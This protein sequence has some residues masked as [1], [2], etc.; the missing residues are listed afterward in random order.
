LVTGKY[1]NYNLT[2]KP[3]DVFCMRITNSSTEWI[4]VYDNGSGDF[5]ALCTPTSSLVRGS[6]IYITGYTNQG[7]AIDIDAFLL[8]VNASTGAYSGFGTYGSDGN[9]YGYQIL[10]DSEENILIRGKKNSNCWL[11]KPN[12][13]WEKE[14]ECLTTNGE[15]ISLTNDNNYILTGYDNDNFVLVKLD[16]EG[17]QLWKKYY[18]YKT[19]ERPFSV[20]QTSD[21]GFLIAGTFQKSFRN[22]DICLIKTDIN[23][24]DYLNADQAVLLKTNSK[25]ILQNCEFSFY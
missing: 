12:T 21:S 13:T 11:F 16:L 8:V 14:I 1:I 2:A 19:V 18:N 24:N 23:G 25:A 10:F 17:N 3:E 22:D 4:E 7:D 20:V 5:S 15:L 9:E 6:Y